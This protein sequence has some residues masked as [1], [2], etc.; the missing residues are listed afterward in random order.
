MFVKGGGNDRPTELGCLWA[1]A[2]ASTARYLAPQGAPEMSFAKLKLGLE[3]AT[4]AAAALTLQIWAM[5][6]GHSCKWGSS[7]GAHRE[8]WRNLWSS[9]ALVGHQ[10]CAVVKAG[11]GK[12]QGGV[13]QWLFGFK[14]LPDLERRYQRWWMCRARVCQLG[15]ENWEWYGNVE[16]GRVDTT[17]TPTHTPYVQRLDRN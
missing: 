7:S 9:S 16:G 5:V 14:G 10:A 4:W 12:G 1:T 15:S 13:T 8:A 2:V 17:T 6:R 3:L 11:C